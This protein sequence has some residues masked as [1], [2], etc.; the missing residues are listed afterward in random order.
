VLSAVFAVL[1]WQY[2]LAI[3]GNRGKILC[4]TVVAISLAYG[5]FMMVKPQ[6][7][8]LPAV[9]SARR[10][11]LR[12]ETHIPFVQSFDYLNHNPRF[13]KLL[14]LD[15]S[16]PAYY[17][18]KDYVKP[19]GQWGEQVFPNV[20]TPEEILPKLKELHIS[21]V[22]DVQ[23]TVSG[24]RVPPDYPGLV[25]EFERPGQRVYRVVPGG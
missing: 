4:A 12:R 24:F 1:G 8:G 18:D 20:S 11:E 9:F 23:S 10:A 22:L 25:L 5:L 2:V 14:I 17:S 15:R 6:L 21:H 13:T 16:V 3:T 19:L 7:A